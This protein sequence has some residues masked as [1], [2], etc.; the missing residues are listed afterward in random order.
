[1]KALVKMS[2]VWET[3]SFVFLNI[4][5]NRLQYKHLVNM[6]DLV[7]LS[8]NFNTLLKIHFHGS[9]MFNNTTYLR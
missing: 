5:T 4:L 2:L 6:T 3:A 1:M 8:N 7:V 9:S